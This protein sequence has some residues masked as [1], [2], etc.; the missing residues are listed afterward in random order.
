[1]WDLHQEPCGVNRGEQGS[2]VGRN[3]GGTGV[4]AHRGP[5]LPWH[6]LQLLLWRQWAVIRGYGMGNHTIRFPFLKTHMVQCGKQMVH[7]ERA[8]WMPGCWPPERGSRREMAMLSG[9]LAAFSEYSNRWPY[10]GGDDFSWIYWDFLWWRGSV[11]V[12]LVT[13]VMSSSLQLIDCS[14]PGSS[15]HGSLQPRILEWAAMPLSRGFSHPG[16]QVTPLMSPAL[17]GRFFLFF[18]AFD[19]FPFYFFNICFLKN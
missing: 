10:A 1:M 6:G 4:S 5:A 3:Q 12:C 14:P 18:L 2:P 16:I 15:V 13:S 7:R 19:L 11:W 8:K 9:L 17:A